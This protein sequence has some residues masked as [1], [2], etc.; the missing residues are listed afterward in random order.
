MSEIITKIEKKIKHQDEIPEMI[1][2]INDILENNC[3]ILDENEI[4]DLMNE[5][6]AERSLEIASEMYFVFSQIKANK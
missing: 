3:H 2:R 5:K 1:Q 6:Y 4:T